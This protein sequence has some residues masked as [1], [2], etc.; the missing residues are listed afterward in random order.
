MTRR[1]GLQSPGR[2]FATSP[3]RVEQTGYAFPTPGKAK[4]FQTAVS[5][6]D[7]AQARTQ[8]L[9]GGS[10]TQANIAENASRG[11]TPTGLL[12]N[13]LHGNFGSAA[14]NLATS[15]GKEGADAGRQQVDAEIARILA[16]PDVQALPAAQ[17]AG[18]LRAVMQRLFLR[19]TAA[20]GAESITR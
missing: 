6:W 10:D 2:L 7:A 18:V 4:D 3:Q 14:T 13:L 15:L 19:G 20:T 17:R 8:R 12:T 1:R 16:S 5:A 11:G 9:L